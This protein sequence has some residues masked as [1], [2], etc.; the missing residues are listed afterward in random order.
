[1]G[2]IHVS[3]RCGL[4][5]IHYAF[6]EVHEE[7]TAREKKKKKTLDGKWQEFL[8]FPIASCPRSVKDRI[9]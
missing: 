6:C 8:L 2:G 3:R 7:Q 1:M 5:T 9:K 4:I